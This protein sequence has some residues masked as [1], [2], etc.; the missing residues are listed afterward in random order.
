MWHSQYG[1]INAFRNSVSGQVTNRKENP[2]TTGRLIRVQ[3][4]EG[5]YK[6]AFVRKTKRMVILYQHCKSSCIDFLTFG[7]VKPSIKC[8]TVNHP[9]YF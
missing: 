9:K 5:P 2:I 8:L 4:I 3:C 1:Q 7:R 6:G